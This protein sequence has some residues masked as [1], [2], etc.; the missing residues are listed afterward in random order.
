VPEGWARTDLPTGATFTDKLN[1]IQVEASRA[2]TAPTTASVQAN[3]LP[4]LQSSVRGF[5]LGQI[6]IVPRT[7]G[8]A[9]LVT[10]QGASAPD[11]VTG[12]SVTQAI[13]LYRFW[14]NGTLVTITLTSPKGADNV[15][16]W[17]T[18]TNSFG[19]Q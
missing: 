10:Y 11:S 5:K 17:K 18:V 3:D 1:S 6:S 8:S 2:A 14:K 9:L 15:D 16:P 19:W 4:G 7:A 12:K 13:E